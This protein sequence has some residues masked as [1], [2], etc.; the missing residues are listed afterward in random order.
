MPGLAVVASRLLVPAWVL[1]LTGL[2]IADGTTDVLPIWMVGLGARVGL[3]PVGMLRALLGA[4]LLVSGLML[5]LGTWARSLAIASMVFACFSGVAS[6]A[7]APESGRTIFLG[8]V[9]VLV[10]GGLLAL[11][12][13]GG[14]RPA[15]PLSMQW[16]AIGAVAVAVVSSTLALQL[17]IRHIDVGI[18]GKYRPMRLLESFELDFAN[19]VGSPLAETGLDAHLP[20]VVQQAQQGRSYIV[21]YNPR[22]GSCHDLFREHFG[23]SV[24]GRVFA[25]KTPPAPDAVLLP[26]DQPEEIDCPSCVKLELRGGVVWHIEPR[27]EPVVV[28]VQ[29]G[30]IECVGI[31]CLERS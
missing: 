21:L 11:V 13:R 5:L 3:D 14:R 26:S 4:E 7:A 16:Q 23:G 31:A 15:A 8:S 17:P 2:Q 27:T 24:D 28:V 12:L 10:S 30:V 19:A 20:S 18:E 29:D 25:I 6:I 1:V 22:C 9:V